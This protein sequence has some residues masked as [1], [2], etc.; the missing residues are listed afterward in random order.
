MDIRASASSISEVKQKP[1]R[2]KEFTNLV[3]SS[4]PEAISNL[5]AIASDISYSSLAE[6]ALILLSRFRSRFSD[7]LTF[8]DKPPQSATGRI[9]LLR[10]LESW[11]R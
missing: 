11:K 8:L 9:N 6:F 10:P 5:I 7:N 2:E 4:P 1:E 3:E